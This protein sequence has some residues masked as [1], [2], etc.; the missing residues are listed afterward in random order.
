MKNRFKIFPIAFV[1]GI[2]TLNSCGN[3]NHNETETHEAITET[4]VVVEPEVV[5][6]TNSPKSMLE[7][8]AVA[9]GGMDKLKALNDVE[10]DYHYTKSD[11]TQDIS[12]ERYIFEK[13]ISWARYTKHEI[14]VF[15]GIEGD[16][17]QFFDGEKAMVYSGGVASDNPEAIGGSQFLRQA[18]YMWFTM[19]FKL[20]DP[21]IISEYNGQEEMDGTMYD[22]VTVTYDPAITKK[23]QNDIYILYIN[24]T[25]YLVEN[26]KFSLPAFGVND[27]ILLAKVTYK[28]MDG[29]QVISKREMFSP[30]PEGGMVPMLTQRIENIKFNNG[31]TAEQLSKEV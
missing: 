8:M 31:F 15:P 19:M 5:Y 16:A 13:E 10:F 22:V 12:Q 30:S 4:E 21:G 18:N 7:A 3:E 17:V 28:E 23:E 6:D 24:P 9:C 27:P 14:N 26:F 29:I 25:S 1:L 11:G 2:V 20:T